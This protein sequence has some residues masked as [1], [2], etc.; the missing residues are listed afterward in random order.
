MHYEARKSIWK[1]DL[2]YEN[3]HACPDGC[4]L[5]EEALANSECCSECNISRW[6][7]GN[8]TI[9]A[10]VIRHFPLIPR[11]QRMWRSVEIVGMLIGYTKHGSGDGI[12]R[13]VVDSHV[14]KHIDND[15]VFSDFGADIRKSKHASS[16]IIGWYQ[17]F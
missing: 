12:M 5:F 7:E 9:A 1:L 10:K 4:V 17:S 13:S 16:S 11:I 8:T 3:I 14:W 15:P 2:N 6:L